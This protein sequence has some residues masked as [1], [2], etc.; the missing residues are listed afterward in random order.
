MGSRPCIMD[1]NAL[2]HDQSASGSMKS[3]SATKPADIVSRGCE[4]EIRRRLVTLHGEVY[5]IERRRFPQ[6]RMMPAARPIQS[7]PSSNVDAK[8]DIAF[9]RKVAFLVIGATL[10]FRRSGPGVVPF[11]QCEKAPGMIRPRTAPLHGGEF[12]RTEEPFRSRTG[13]PQPACSRRT[14]PASAADKEGASKAPTSP[15]RARNPCRRRLARPDAFGSNMHAPTS[16]IPPLAS[17]QEGL[18]PPGLV[19][20]KT[21]LG[22]G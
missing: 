21:P 17:L 8:R 10:G 7:M 15:R 3:A 4:L 6:A 5:G 20:P 13:V 2:A 12:P 1:S 16:A 9:E 11:P 22:S 19:I 18:Q 14:V